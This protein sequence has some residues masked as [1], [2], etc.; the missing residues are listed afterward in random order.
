MTTTRL[1]HVE[2]P[3]RQDGTG[4]PRSYV[5][6]AAL[7]DSVTH[8]VGDASNAGFRGWTRIMAAAMA[9]AHD[10]SVCN[11]ARPGATAAEVR[12]DQLPQALL[13]RPHVASLV[14]GLNDAL[15]STWSA[16]AV[17]RDLLMCAEAL[18]AQGALLLTVHLHDHSR[19]LHLPNV[20]ARPLR[21]RIDVLNSVYDE[22]HA[23]YGGIQ[24][25]LSRHPGVYDR[26]MW[27]CDRLHPSE[28]GHRALADEFAALLEGRGLTFPLPG[29]EVDG[30]PVTRR[31][32][33][34]WITS[35]VIPW[36]GRRMRD[37]GPHFTASLARSARRRLQGR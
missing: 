14:V 34:R 1:V 3:T 6:F 2:A 37:L 5:R 15:A 25:D 9:K 32:E 10:V 4:A 36:L 28:L 8:G 11:V 16:V 33:L 18:A 27:S 21:R 7:G 24:V 22:I 35:E 26:E 12:R 13:H 20:L 19:V 29:L 31:D 23:R 30:P 17:R